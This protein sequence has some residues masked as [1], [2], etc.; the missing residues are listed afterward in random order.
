METINF[1]LPPQQQPCEQSFDARPAAVRQWA[2][3]LP[4][5]NLGE[6]ARLLHATLQ[7]TNRL[8][9]P[10]NHRL[11]MVETLAPALHTVL[12][13]LQQRLAGQPLPLSSQTRR[14]SA[15][16]SQ[17]L[18][19]FVIA[20]QAVLDEQQ[21]GSWLF[22]MTHH[23]LWPLC[24]HRMLHYLGHICRV[25][26]L[27]HQPAPAG[28]WHA[29]H[30]LFLQ[31]DHHGRRAERVNLSWEKGR[32]ESIENCYLQQL[33]LA[34]LDP[35]LLSPGELDRVMDDLPGWAPLARL[36]APAD[37]QPTLHAY[38]IN[39]K[40]DSPH[41][42]SASQSSQQD[43][44]SGAALLLDLG[45]LHDKISEQLAKAGNG[46]DSKLLETL[47]R[48]WQ[49]PIGPRGARSHSHARHQAAI[50][51][52]ALFSLLRS[53]NRHR[54]D[55]ISDQQFSN[56][57]KPLAAI[58][59]KSVPAVN[60]PADN[61]WDNIFFATELNGNS[62]SMDSQEMN[63]H[64]ISAQEHDASD[65]GSC[66]EFDTHD[67]PAM[68]VG[69]LLGLRRHPGGAMQLS[70]VRW[71]QQRQESVLCGVMVLSNQLEAILMIMQEGQQRTALACLLGIGLDGHPQLFLPNLPGLAQR[72]LSLVVDGYEVPI[73][74]H[75]RIAASPLFI[76]H[77][78]SLQPS[79]EAGKTMDEHMD[80]DELKR[81]LHQLIQ[82]HP[83]SGNI[84][85]QDFSDLWDSI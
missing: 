62:W 64:Y 17:L 43:H 20:Y 84:A 31:A 26:R 13:G 39:L 81:R 76:A 6:T 75:Q 18:V 69:E 60:K 23:D 7:E 22:R 83:V 85:K 38:W 10:L 33:L 49:V 56:E 52:S 54:R 4:L 47:A 58:A 25:H 15:F 24:I 36:R 30:R 35:S 14:I 8:I 42:S 27:V 71:I 37:W 51:I 11:T 63:Y 59:K 79:L 80:L 82:Q 57:L 34:L 1:R 16:N 48:A 74:L 41:T 77:H 45:A 28:L 46:A 66:L 50:G 68:D 70:E 44:E 67:L 32:K 53:E 21:Q 29:M 2:E 40:L 73:Q 12:S 19:E 9:L 61:I 65:N 78:F 5:G 3:Q 72:Q 55:G